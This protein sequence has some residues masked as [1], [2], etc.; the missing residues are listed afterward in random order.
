MTQSTDPRVDTYI[1]AAPAF[2]QPILTVL[3]AHI[4]AACPSATEAIK[5][6]MPMFQYKAQNLANIAAFKAHV[7]FGVMLRGA[8]APVRSIEGG[9]MGNFGKLTRVEDVPDAATVAKAVA[10]AVERIDAGAKMR[11][12]PATPKPLPAIPEDLAA[13]LAAAPA[14]A[15]NFHAFAPGQRREYLDWILEAKRPE[16]RIKRIETTVAQSAENKTR[17][18]KYANC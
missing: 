15:A 7:S 10:A 9:G 12:S 13:A 18:W 6:G 5:W 16:T 1:A 8:A 14:A 3:R 2:A 11:T 17:N 4:H